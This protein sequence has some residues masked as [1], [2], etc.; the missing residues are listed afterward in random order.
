MLIETLTFTFLFPPP[1]ECPLIRS[2]GEAGKGDCQTSGMEEHSKE[3]AVCVPGST[4]G[5][6]NP[7]SGALT[8]AGL[9]SKLPVVLGRS[10]TPWGKR[11]KACFQKSSNHLKL[12]QPCHLPSLLFM[13]F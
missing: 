7:D 8:T 5:H 9:G 12:S 2:D 10:S 13:G 4:Q 3:P 11:G 6:C 1:K